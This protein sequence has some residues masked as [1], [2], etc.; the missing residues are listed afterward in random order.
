MIYDKIKALCKAQGRS[1]HSV[2][3]ACGLANGTIRKWNDFNPKM[4]SV[5][6][7]AHELKVSVEELLE[8]VSP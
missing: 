6:K 7:V 2:E 5:V 4:M 1:I 8:D 3:M